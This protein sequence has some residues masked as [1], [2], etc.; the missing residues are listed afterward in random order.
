MSDRQ[1][2]TTR[3]SIERARSGIA[4]PYNAIQQGRDTFN[5]N[6]MTNRNCGHTARQTRQ[7]TL[8]PLIHT[9]L[10]DNTFRRHTLTY[11]DKR[12]RASG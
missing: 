11:G 3:N 5:R 8:N 2:F 9:L 10:R 7:Y 6:A 1:R 12:R 4:N